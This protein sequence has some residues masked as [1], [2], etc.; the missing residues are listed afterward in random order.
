MEPAWF[1][2]SELKPGEAE[3][4]TVIGLF[5]TA[6]DAHSAQNELIAA[7]IEQDRISLVTSESNR[8]LRGD[9]HD[10]TEAAEGAGVGATAG[11]LA[12][13]AAG[14]LASLGLLAIP[15]IGGLLA[16]G[17]IVAALTGAGIG[18]AAGGLIGGLVGLGIPEHEA[19]VYAEGVNRGGTLLSVDV[20]DTDA[21]RVAAILSQ[22]NAVDIDKRASE[23]ESGG[24]QRK[25]TR[26]GSTSS[27]SFGTSPA[28]TTGGGT[29]MPA[30]PGSTM[31]ARSRGVERP[32]G[33]ASGD[34]A[35]TDVTSTGGMDPGTSDLGSA[36]RSSSARIY[37]PR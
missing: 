34:L 11:A 25:Y 19:E 17:P 30:S 22:H 2:P 16:L 15:G 1:H 27:T 28:T 36:R 13:G 12:G 21:D 3:M 14:L 26:T 20:A 4:K 8:D 23:W 6:S 5:D 37:N 32:A 24:W 18:A 33:P 10:R 35:D 9:T 7:G 31:D 29:G